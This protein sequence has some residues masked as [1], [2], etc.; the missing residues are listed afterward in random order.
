MNTDSIPALLPPGSRVLTAVSGGCDSI[1][2]LHLLWTKREEWGLEVSAAHYEHGIRGEASLRDAAFVEDF[3]RARGIPCA[4][5]HGDVPAFA[6]EQGLGIEEAARRLRYAFLEHTADQLGCDR[7]ATAHNADDN[8]ETMLLNLVRGSGLRGLGGIPPV[9]GRIVRPLLRVTRQEIEEYLRE[10]GLPHVEDASNADERYRRNRLRQRV[11]PVLRELNPALAHSLGDTAALLRQDEDCLA[12]LADDFIE[13]YYQNDS[14]PTKELRELHP[15]VASRVLR[16]LCERSLE[17]KHVEETISFCRGSELGFLD[18]PG[19]RLRREQGR[20]YF[21]ETDVT[22]IPD[23]S[24]RP[25]ETLQIPE[26]GILVQADLVE[27]NQKVNSLFKTYCIKYENIRGNEILCTGRRPGD[28]MRPAYR[29][30][31]KSLKALFL[32]RG[33]TRQ[34]RDRVLV[35]RDA[36]GILAVYDLALDERS[37][38]REGETALRLTIYNHHNHT[39]DKS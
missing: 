39:E 8:A 5:E 31:G 35:F 22:P 9:R 18:L 33:M 26:L 30:C 21:C 13:K 27:Y 20:L 6:R 19:Q 37:L 10:N 23:R 34:E 2:L 4:V 7:I 38:P 14:L 24:I 16:R 25:G 3:C 36:A 28:R 1:C 29:G 15:A 17:R 12:S 32:E 11:L